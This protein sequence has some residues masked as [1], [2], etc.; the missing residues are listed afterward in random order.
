MRAASFQDPALGILSVRQNWLKLAWL[1]KTKRVLP[2]ISPGEEMGEAVHRA[3]K[4]L[5]D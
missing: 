2:E 5:G 3:A 4:L 1:T